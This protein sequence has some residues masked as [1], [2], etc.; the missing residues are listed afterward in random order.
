MSSR[1]GCGIILTGMRHDIKFPSKQAASRDLG[2]TIR[3]I[4]RLIESGQIFMYHGK[5]YCID[6]LYEEDR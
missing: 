2:V 5:E 1:K 4:D 3:F 6:E